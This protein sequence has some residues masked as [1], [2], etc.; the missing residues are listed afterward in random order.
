MSAAIAFF[1]LY[2]AS[3]FALFWLIRLAVRYGVD[4]ALRKNRSWLDRGERSPGA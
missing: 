2:A 1:L 4:D 3:V